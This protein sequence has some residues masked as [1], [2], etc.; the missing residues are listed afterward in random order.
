MPRLLLILLAFA[1]FAL[2]A[3]AGCP[4]IVSQSP[5]ITLALEWLGLGDCIV[6][7]SRYDRRELP[8]TGGVIDPDADAIA[9]LDPQLMIAADWTDAAKWQAM[10]PTGA[11]ALRVDG[12]HGMA[13]AERMLHE[14]GRAANVADIDARVARFAAEWRA[15]AAR[16]AGKGR[17]ALLMTACSGAPYSFGRGT[18]LYELFSRAGFQVVADHDG[19]RNFSPDGPADELPR[20]LDAVRPEIVFALKNSRDEACNAALARPGTP[21]VP[22]DG[23]RFNHPGPALLD[24]LRQ[25]QEALAE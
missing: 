4:R 21:I 10:A 18:T 7:V 9:I 5:Y 16:V 22:L 8:R 1:A 14:V 23:E 6:G 17:R 24:G 19:I 25:L 20:W 2:P 12:F 11:V 13:D 3:H 15:A